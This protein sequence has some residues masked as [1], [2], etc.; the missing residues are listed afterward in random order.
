M[1]AIQTANIR[2]VRVFPM[3]TYNDVPSLELYLMIYNKIERNMLKIIV[4]DFSFTYIA[5]DPL[6][7]FFLL[8]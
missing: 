3:P 4:G 2:A 5:N 8:L 7:R 6:D 1:H